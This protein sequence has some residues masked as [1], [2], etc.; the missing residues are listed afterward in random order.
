M[1]TFYRSDILQYFGIEK[2]GGTK[3]LDV[4]CYDGQFLS[5]YNARLRVGVDLAPVKKY[6]IGIVAADASFLPFK[7]KFDKI[8]AFDVLEHVPDDKTFLSSEDFEETSL[9]N[10]SKIKEYTYWNAPFWKFFYFPL[11][12]L[13]KFTL[14]LTKRL[15]LIKIKKVSQ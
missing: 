11:R 8:F 1:G 10:E 2:S 14:A 4:G 3:V 9:K 15:L 5:D 12:F 7:I 6:D 13:W